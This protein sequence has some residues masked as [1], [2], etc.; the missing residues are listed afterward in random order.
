[1][2]LLMKTFRAIRRVNLA[3]EPT[4]RHAWVYLRAVYFIRMRRRLRTL[5]SH[6][7]VRTNIMHNVKSIYGANNRMNLLL[8]PLAVIETLNADSKILVIGP[9][10]ENDL[11]SL[12]GLGFKLT[13]V[14]GLDLISYSPYIE[15]GDMHAIPFP[16]DSF[17][18]V[19]CGWTL[20]Y[21]TNPAKAAKEMIRVARPGGLMAIGLEYSRLSPQD[22]RTLVG[23]EIQ[24]L[25]KVGG[26]I[27]STTQI[28][29]LF[30]D[31]VDTVFFEHDAP[32]KVSHSAERLVPDVSNVALIFRLPTPKRTPEPPL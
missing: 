9:R 19:I 30:A 22:E 24:E 15:L 29:E 11:Y 16:D 5:D 2:N 8:Y 32:R 27:N 31:N 25:D 12:F 6:D 23:Y 4:L 10:N 17:D 1:M 3:I 28:R 13:N 18:A 21:S 14:R 7:A 20:S 26:R